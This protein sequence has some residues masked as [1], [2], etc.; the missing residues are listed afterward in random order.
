MPDLPLDSLQSLHAS[1]L[2]NVTRLP[3]LAHGSV[4]ETFIE[5]TGIIELP[6]P[7]PDI[8]KLWCSN[9]GIQRLPILPGC[10]FLHLAGC[11]QL[12][13]LPVQL[14]KD[15]TYLNCRSC[16]ALQHL[17]AELPPK[18]QMMSIQ[19]CTALERLPAQ[20]PASLTSLNREGCSSLQQ[21]P[22]LTG[23]GLKHLR[24]KGCVLLGGVQVNGCDNLVVHFD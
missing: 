17:P 14:P 7:L 1:G 20:L 2:P 3:V 15:L 6:D 22:D 8:D 4:K 18:L 16:S 23:C 5:S 10:K 13:Q 12:Q 11:Q 21:L 24:L 9:M 19:G